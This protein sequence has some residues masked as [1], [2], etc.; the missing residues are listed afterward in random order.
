MEIAPR[1]AERPF[2][3]ALLT[4]IAIDESLKLCHKIGSFAMPITEEVRA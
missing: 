2:P 1:G 3:R 4:A